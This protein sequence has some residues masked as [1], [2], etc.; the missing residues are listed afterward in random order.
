MTEQELILTSLLGCRRI[1][2]YV[3]RPSMDETCHK[4]FEEILARRQAG[5]PLQYILGSCDFMGFTLKVDERVLIPRPETELLIEYVLNQ[6][7]GWPEG[8]PLDV[9]DVGTGSGNI[10]ISIARQLPSSRVVAVD[11]SGPALEVAR[12]NAVDHGVAGQIRFFQSNLLKVF[13]GKTEKFDFILANL[14][15]IPTEKI[16]TLPQ[17]VRHEPE[18]AL[19]G[20]ADGL[21]YYRRLIKESILFLRKGGLLVFEIGEEQS[22]AFQAILSDNKRLTLKTILKDYAGCDR[23]IALECL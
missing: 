5:E 10:A 16:P 2:L 4:R 22:N 21:M 19:D 15:Y 9:L 18:P 3:D 12:I 20:G 17:D 13:S 7:R 11:V 1:D 23:I 6:A 14:P 8:K